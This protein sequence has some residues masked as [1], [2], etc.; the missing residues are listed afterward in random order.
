MRR[1]LPPLETLL[2]RCYYVR[3]ERISRPLLPRRWEAPAGCFLCL[4]FHLYV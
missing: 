1:C 2:R 3:I 4:S